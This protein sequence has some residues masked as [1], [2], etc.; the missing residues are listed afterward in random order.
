M[1]TSNLIK[2]ANQ[3][4]DFFEA[5]PDSEQAAIDVATH[6]NHFWEPSMRNGFLDYIVSSGKNELKP[7]VCKAL[8]MI[9]DARGV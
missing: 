6:I 1:N 7:I 2:M 9:R 5:M 8:P 3:I 4:G